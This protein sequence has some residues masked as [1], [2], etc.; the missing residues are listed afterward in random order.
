MLSNYPCGVTGNEDI[1]GDHLR[2]VSFTI[3]FPYTIFNDD[4]EP[5]DQVI[6]SY[7]QRQ[8]IKVDM[9]TVE[10]LSDDSYRVYIAYED[11]LEMDVRGMDR[12]DIKDEII[13]YTN[14]Q[15]FEACIDLRDDTVEIDI[16]IHRC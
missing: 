9:S 2:T 12:C 5:L 4:N 7:I 3:T 6:K 15:I 8:D 14:D 1:F 10:H 13:R 11:D 16:D